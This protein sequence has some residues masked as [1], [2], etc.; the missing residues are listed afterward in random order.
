MNHTTQYTTHKY[1]ENV[2]L[3]ES[4]VLQQLL[5]KICSESVSLIEMNFIVKK[6]YNELVQTAL[7]Q[8]ASFTYQSLKTRMFDQCSDAILSYPSLLEEK[9]VT[10][11]LARA[12]I[13]PS[14][15]CFDL[16]NLLMNPKNIR[17]D[18]FYMQRVSN[19][20][21]AVIGVDVNGSKIGG[22]IDSNL[23]I[24]PD[25]MAATGNSIDYTVNYYKSRVEGDAK[26]Y[27]ALHLIVTPEYIK[28]MKDKH[29]DLI[30]IAI[31]VDRGLSSKKALESLPGEYIDEEKGL[32]D[33]G[34]IIPGA[35]GVG[36]VLN[37]AFV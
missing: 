16:M 9:A 22:P 4:A 32:N 6:L 20:K 34:Y 30:I 10:V 24:I 21:G 28:S 14:Q 37:N 23:V 36:E 17:Q 19:D 18:H 13:M 12:G 3:L 7:T 26:K 8:Y 5:A 15:E 11:S 31:R 29:P 2:H 35:G 33:I 25:P 27:I 1:G